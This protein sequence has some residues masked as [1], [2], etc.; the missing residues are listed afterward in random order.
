MYKAVA[1]VDDFYG[2]PERARSLALDH[3]RWLPLGDHY[4]YE[5]ENSFYTDELIAR[6]RDLVGEPIHVAPK[7]MGFGVF[8][9]YPA[10]ATVDDTT[11]FDDTDWSAIIYLVPDEWCKGGITFYRH[12]ETGLSGPPTEPQ[13]QALGFATTEEFLEQVYEP[14]KK[15]PEAWE[16]TTHIGMRFNR[17]V[18]LRG[19]R[20]F[21]RASTGFGDSPENGRLTQ[22]F[23]FDSATAEE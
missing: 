21:H 5:T 12:V 15:R 17:M 10:E 1:V 7:R 8:A 9:Y 22:R 20:L 19:S 3:A 23:F 14:D 4:S 13:A 11:H 18:L 6:L 16:E 2:E